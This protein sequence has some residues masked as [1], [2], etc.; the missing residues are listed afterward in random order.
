MIKLNLAFVSVLS[1]A[2]IGCGGG[3]STPSNAD[4][5]ITKENQETVRYF[6]NNSITYSL[7]FHPREGSKTYTGR[8]IESYSFSSSP[9]LF[10]N[11]ELETI[12]KSEII[13]IDG[14][15]NSRTLEVVQFPEDWDDSPTST[16]FAYTIREDG[17][18]F[19]I[20]YN[21]SDESV[22][23]TEVLPGFLYVGYQSNKNYSKRRTDNGNLRNVV[24]SVKVNKIEVVKTD[25]GY[26]DAFKLEKVYTETSRSGDV[27]SI[28]GT[29]WVHPSI[30]V[31][32]A[33]YVSTESINSYSTDV[34]DVEYVITNTNLSY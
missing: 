3:D 28:V 10:R 5:P 11:G 13:T 34:F 32:K 15:A 18:A 33:K 31:I 20:G 12:T 22:Y 8:Y 26:F 2:L 4:F 6:P 1:L 21:A 9:D 23:G 30:G 19:D 27:D 17:V 14:Q 16:Q 24:E 25:L 7:K 29:F